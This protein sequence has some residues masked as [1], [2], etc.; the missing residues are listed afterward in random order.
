[1]KKLALTTIVVFFSVCY[2]GIQGQPTQPQ[3]DQLKLMQQFIGTW[4]ADYAK[5]TIVVWNCQP[6]GKVII[7]TGT[8]LIRGQ[9]TS[10]FINNISFNSKES[11]FYG[12]V[13]FPSGNKNTWTSSYVSEKKSIGEYCANFNPEKVWAKFEIIHESPTA[14]TYYQFNMQGAKTAEWNFKIV[15]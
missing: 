2:F 1:M 5:D 11:K 12:F 15:K 8:W 4:Q 14:F 10:S 13:L 3:L 7:I 6:Y 9:K